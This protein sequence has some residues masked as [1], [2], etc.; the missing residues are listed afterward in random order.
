MLELRL[1]S[2]VAFSLYLPLLACRLSHENEFC[3][4]SSCTWSCFLRCAFLLVDDWLVLSQ[5]FGSYLFI[6]LITS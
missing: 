2:L 3:Q 5:L 1:V 6:C 4:N